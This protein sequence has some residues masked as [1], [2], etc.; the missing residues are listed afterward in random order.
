MLS[1]AFDLAAAGLIA[2]GGVEVN[3][4]PLAVPVCASLGL[5]RPLG[6]RGLGGRL[7]ASDPAALRGDVGG[8]GPD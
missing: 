7:A 5:M 2:T 3:V 8:D 1:A 6:G 4:G